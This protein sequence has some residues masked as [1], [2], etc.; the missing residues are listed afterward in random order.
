MLIPPASLCVLSEQRI[1]RVDMGHGVHADKSP[2]KRWGSKNPAVDAALGEW[3]ARLSLLS[4][5]GCLCGLLWLIR[6]VLRCG[7]MEHCT[8]TRRD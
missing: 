4:M 3:W 7:A 6:V 2:V 5:R 1:I 8:C